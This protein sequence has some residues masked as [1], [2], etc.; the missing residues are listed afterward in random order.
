MEN[1]SWPCFSSPLSC[2]LPFHSFKYFSV[3]KMVVSLCIPV[4]LILTN[5]FEKPKCLVE[6]KFKG[7]PFCAQIGQPHIL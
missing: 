6:S 5:P 3:S 1:M 2:N 7:A 4:S